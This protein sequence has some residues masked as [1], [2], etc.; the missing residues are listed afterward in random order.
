MCTNN[1][2]FL[3]FGSPFQDEVWMALHLGD[4]KIEILRT[5]HK[6][7]ALFV[8]LQSRIAA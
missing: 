6:L 7:G 3:H 8:E 2:V 1:E 4:M 5:H